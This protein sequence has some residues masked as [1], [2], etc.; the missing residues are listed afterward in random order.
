MRTSRQGGAWTEFDLLKP[1]NSERLSQ[2]QQQQVE[3]QASRTKA[4]DGRSG[5][6]A[7]LAE[8][9]A[10]FVIHDYAVDSD[11]DA[12]DAPPF[13][14]SGAAIPSVT[15]II[16]SH[17]IAQGRTC[18]VAVQWHGHTITQHAY[19]VHLRAT[20]IL[21]ICLLA[22]HVALHYALLLRRKV[23]HSHVL[24]AGQSSP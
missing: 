20:E 17:F 3:W 16:P 13:R 15:I 23:Q 10:H 9:S 14:F 24:R 4:E 22:I 7:R 5:T 1:E 21:P 12:F 6:S 8:M 19:F 18:I 2:L 11:E